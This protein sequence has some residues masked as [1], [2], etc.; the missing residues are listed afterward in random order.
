MTTIDPEPA[1]ENRLLAALPAADAA[2]L[3]PYL[4]PVEL[5]TE[6]IL[7]RPGDTITAVYFPRTAAVTVLTALADG[8]LVEAA[9]VGREGMVGL[10][11]FLGDDVS[12]ALVL[13]QIPGDAW[14]MDTEA[15]RAVVD[16]THPL[17]PRLLRYTAMRLVQVAQI[18]ACNRRHA[19]VARCATWLVLAADGVGSEAF[20]ITHR[21]LAL[22]LGVRRATVA[23][24][25]AALQRAGLIRYRA[26]HLVIV[27]RPGLEAAAGEC[28]RVIRD[29]FDRLLD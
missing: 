11:A 17:H 15:F 24:A 21:F 14:R 9:M 27:D 6:Q 25:A 19:V 10:P 22:V 20:P 18:A 5:A 8:V 1:A 29:A 2:G 7:Y 23:V 12:R 13:C 26:G 16:V 4:E 28:Y 3:R